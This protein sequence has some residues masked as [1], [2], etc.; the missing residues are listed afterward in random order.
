LLEEIAIDAGMVKWKCTQGGSI[1]TRIWAEHGIQSVNLYVEYGEEH[2]EREYLD[3]DACYQVTKLL[4]AVFSR[5][6]ELRNV[7]GRSVGFR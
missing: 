5:K 1:D 4:E 7:V 2:T 3:I 6:R